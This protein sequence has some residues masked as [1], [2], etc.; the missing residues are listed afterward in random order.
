MMVRRV[1]EI[2]TWKD[3]DQFFL[4]QAEAPVTIFASVED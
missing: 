1:H 3:K 2:A 4:L